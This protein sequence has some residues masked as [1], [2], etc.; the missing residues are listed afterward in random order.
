MKRI[1]LRTLRY[2]LLAYCLLDILIGYAGFIPITELAAAQFTVVTGTVIDPNGLPYA[3]GTITPILTSSASPTLGGFAYTPPT[4]ATGLS[5]TGTFTMRLADNTSLLPANTKWNFVVNCGA[6]CVLPAGGT[7]PIVFTLA[8]PITISGTTQDISVQ[9]QAVAPSLTKSSGSGVIAFPGAP[10]GSCFSTQLA[11]NTSSGQLYSCNAAVWQAVTGGVAPAAATAGQ[12]AVSVGAGTTYVAT[13]K[14]WVEA[15]DMLVPN[16]AAN[17]NG[18]DFCGAINLAGQQSP[19]VDAT[20]T[21]GGASGI[22]FLDAGGVVFCHQNPYSGGTA[23]GSTNWKSVNGITGELKLPGVRIVTD[24]EWVSPSNP[25]NLT[26]APPSGGS[27]NANISG[28]TLQM[29]VAPCGNTFLGG[30]LMSNFNVNPNNY[31]AC[32]HPRCPTPTVTLLGAATVTFSGTTVTS[33]GTPF[34]AAM[35]GGRVSNCTA[36]T[37]FA[38]GNPAFSAGCDGTGLI[39]AVPTSSTLT[40]ANNWNGTAGAGQAGVVINPNILVLFHDGGLNVVTDAFGGTIKDVRFDLA[41]E[42][43]TPVAYLSANWQERHLLQQDFFSFNAC[44]VGPGVDETN[45]CGP[46]TQPAFQAAIITD[47]TFVTSIVGTSLSGSTHYAI[48]LPQISVGQSNAGANTYGI[49]VEGWSSFRNSSGG[50][51]EEFLGGTIVG[52]TANLIQEAVDMDGMG[53]GGGTVTAIHCEYEVICLGVGPKNATQNQ[54]IENLNGANTMQTGLIRFFQSTN[55]SAGVGGQIAVNSAN[56]VVTASYTASAGKCIV[57][58]DTWMNNPIS[59]NGVLNCLT[60]FTVTRYR[61]PLAADINTTFTSAPAI[62]A[63]A[64][65]SWGA[66]NTQKCAAF[67]LAA[68]T[69]TANI[70]YNVQTAG[71]SGGTYDLGI[72][73]LNG[74]VRAHLGNVSE[75]TFQGTPPTWVKANWA[76]LPTG[77]TGAFL[78]SGTYFLCM[79]ASATTLQSVLVGG[80]TNGVG[81]NLALGTGAVTAGGTLN[82]GAGLPAFGPPTNGNAPVFVLQ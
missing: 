39:V 13:T 47:K 25:I 53:P 17:L 10:S 60:N 16:N 37:Y 79:T 61:Q 4:Q 18:K 36:Y 59:G 19:F 81:V 67:V 38:S 44:G 21:S 48:H 78:P 30:A 32:G 2:C 50:S 70:S 8:A 12:I 43:T 29:C 27:T 55:Q 75:A 15:A 3:N 7:G 77:A 22:N 62:I 23:K 42:Q 24:N 76:G 5:L 80:A 14:A 52:T 69:L 45:S 72:E 51:A 35:I 64:T 63:A 40:L 20:K 68:D 73:D 46:A 6:G 1:N 28:T 34:T 49:L 58:D 41:G 56:Q 74:N 54:V 82:N 71:T 57:I 9:L 66:A 65:V 31:E 33:T 11:V 26:G